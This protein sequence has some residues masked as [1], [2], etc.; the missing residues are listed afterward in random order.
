MLD[1]TLS[2][3]QVQIKFTDHNNFVLHNNNN[4]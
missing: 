3:L 4:N 1:V 2:L